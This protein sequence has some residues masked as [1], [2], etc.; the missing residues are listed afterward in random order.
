MYTY[1]YSCVYVHTYAF[2]YSYGPTYIHKCI[3]ACKFW[4]VYLFVCM[5][6]FSCVYVCAYIAHTPRCNH[7]VGDVCVYIYTRPPI[8]SRWSTELTFLTSG[9]WR[10]AEKSADNR[11]AG[12][13]TAA[14]PLL[15]SCCAA[16]ANVWYC[17]VCLGQ[18]QG[19]SRLPLTGNLR[20]ML[21][22]HHR[23]PAPRWV[24]RQCRRPKNPSL[25]AW[26]R[27][28]RARGARRRTRRMRLPRRHEAR[29]FNASRRVMT[30]SW[31]P[32]SKSIGSGRRN[33]RVCVHI[34]MCVCV[35]I[36]VGYVY[37]YIYIYICVYIHVYV[38]IYIY[39]YVYIYI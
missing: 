14:A 16:P 22:E 33:C 26:R 4:C 9:C 25:S 27:S 3:S 21:C 13:A 35:R 2:I 15:R 32:R 38:Y 28:W 1:I 36:Y 39:I 23:V 18:R 17:R 10:W 11:R 34:C 8:A 7:Y 6:V 12:T 24:R 5:C 20:M 31:N 19:P 29:S 37:I 30:M